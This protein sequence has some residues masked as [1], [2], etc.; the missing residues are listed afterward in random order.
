[1]PPLLRGQKVLVVNLLRHAR[2]LIVE[3][4]P[5]LAEV[6]V[7]TVEDRDGR[8]IGPFGGWRETEKY[9]ETERLPAGAILDFRLADGEVTPIATYLVKRGVPVVICSGAYIPDRIRRSAP[10]LAYLPKPVSTEEV[11]DRLS[12]MLETIRRQMPPA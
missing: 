4:D 7:Q 11:V 2:I 5:Q 6:F 10:H 3:D 1:L 8:V 9:I 12:E